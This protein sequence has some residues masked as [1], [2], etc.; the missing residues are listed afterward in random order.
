MLINDDV[1]VRE[2]RVGLGPFPV[3]DKYMRGDGRTPEGQFYVCARNPD[4]KYYK[5]LGLN[6][7]APRHAEEALRVGAI[8]IEDY[9]RI[10]EANNNLELPPWNTALGGAIFIH[11]GG[12]HEDWTEGCIAVYNSAIDELF[13]VVRV[14]TPVE[15]L[16]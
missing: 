13:E 4:S 15:V 9:Q 8:S 3:G 11:G 10:S 16:P 2:Y 6:Y 12:A 5:S 14:G 1:L 7:P